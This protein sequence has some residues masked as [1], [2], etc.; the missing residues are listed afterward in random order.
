VDKQNPLTARVVANRLWQHHFGEGLVRTP[1]NFGFLGSPPTHPD[2]LDLLASELM[3]GEWRLKRIHKMI[4]MSKT[5]RQSSIHPLAQRYSEFDAANRYW[6]RAERR[7]LDSEQLRDSLLLCSGRLDRSIGGPS[8]RAPINYE[9]LEGLSKKGEAYKASPVDESRRRG[10]YM[11]SKRSLAV[12]MM[13]VFDSCD[14]T[15]P[16]GRRDVSTVAPQALTLL[17][18][19]WVHGESLAMAARVL[20]SGLDRVP[21]VSAAWRIT[22][23]RE[24]TDRE[25]MASIDFVS[26]LQSKASS[27]TNTEL[28]AFAA[29]CHTIINTNEFIYLD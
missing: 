7:R 25:K 26:R 21:R 28:L 22:L 17:N 29:L 1:D 10:V 12:P 20:A 16:T 11:F 24:P 9:A 5:Y 15:A 2:L 8:F 6:W 4:V 18:N 14:T 13:A 27:E 19:E 23:S 3:A